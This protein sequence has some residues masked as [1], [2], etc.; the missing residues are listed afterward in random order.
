MSPQERDVAHCLDQAPV[1]IYPAVADHIHQLQIDSRNRIDYTRERNG[2]ERVVV[3]GRLIPAVSIVCGS[4]VKLFQQSRPV[5]YR[6]EVPRT[7][8]HRPHPRAAE[9]KNIDQTEPAAEI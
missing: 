8:A 2:I 5:V 9:R 6:E 4:I 7:L 3:V 1:R